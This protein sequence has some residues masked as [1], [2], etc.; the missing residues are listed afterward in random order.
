MAETR[1]IVSSPSGADNCARGSYLLLFHVSLTCSVEK[2]GWL[3][4]RRGPVHQSQ[5][6]PIHLLFSHADSLHPFSCFLP[7]IST[8]N[9]FASPTASA[10]RYHERDQSNKKTQHHS[11]LGTLPFPDPLFPASDRTADHPTLAY[12]AHPPT[13]VDHT[14][15]VSVPVGIATTRGDGVTPTTANSAPPPVLAPREPVP[16]SRTRPKGRGR[17]RRLYTVTTPASRRRSPSPSASPAMSPCRLIL[18][19]PLH[20]PVASGP[21]AA[22]AHRRSEMRTPQFRMEMSITNWHLHHCPPSVAALVTP[23]PTVAAPSFELAILATAPDSNNAPQVF[24]TVN[25]RASDD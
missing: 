5:G 12:Q 19:K 14:H 15:A 10:T 21:Y 7:T 8:L 13:P 20:K 17:K 24:Y 9:D 11:S 22:M 18:C 6:A 16:S 3:D 23:T 1:A 4:S 2:V 25:G